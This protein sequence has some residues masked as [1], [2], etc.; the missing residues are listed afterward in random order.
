MLRT[1]NSL[2]SLTCAVPAVLF[3]LLGTSPAPAQ[4]A[5]GH[6]MYAPHGT[7]ETYLV[8][9]NGAVIHTWPGGYPPGN[10][11]YHEPDGT[12]IRSGMAP[13]NPGIGGSGGAV[14]RLQLDGTV[15]WDFLWADDDHW[16]HHDIELMP[17]GNVLIVS[18]DKLTVQDAIDAGR[19]PALISGSAWLPDAIVEIQQTGPTTGTVV[20]EWHVMDHVIQDHDVTK[21]NFGVVA[22]HPE[23]LDINYPPSTISNGD[24]NH[25]NSIDYDPDSDLI[26]IN[27]PF[28]DEFYLIDHSTTTAEAAGHT[29]GNFGKGGDFLYRWGNPAAYRAG[30]SADQTLFNPH[31]TKF[32]PDGLPGE[33]NIIL[34]NNQYGSQFGQDYSAV[35]E[36][37]LPASF[38]LAPGAAYGPSGPIWTYIAPNPTDL[39]SSGLSN[40]E[41]LP[42]GNTLVDSGRQDGWLFE[43]TSAG[44]KV[45]EYFNTMPTPNALVFQVSYYERTLWGDVQSLSTSAGGSVGFDLIAGSQHAGLA[46]FVL[47]SLS[48]TDPGLPAGAS[49]LPLNFDAYL[50]FTLTKPNSAI[51]QG[52][53]GTLDA[54]G[55]ATAS[56][57][58]SPGAGSAAAG[59]T[60]HHAFAVID[61]LAAEVTHTS[62]AVPISLLP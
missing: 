22:D 30:T 41:R 9:V 48:G 4:V 8:D 20:W 37:E 25:A 60:V 1:P 31:G 23:L 12:L 32:I 52:S 58:L 17:N 44:Q 28:Q 2:R 21:A 61:V 42:N 46:Y 14:Q 38:A 40:A 5:P 19:D 10:G 11:V 18:W 34:F 35:F 49:V 57:V 24:W 51:L 47:G 62:N 54:L 29:G 33:G 45:W 39:Y 56:F 3:L 15:L 50:L 55:K 16:G 43:V 7:T 13:G 36:L 26:L 59:S 53:L 27:F 6:R